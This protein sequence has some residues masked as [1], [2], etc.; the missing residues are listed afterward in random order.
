ML[1]RFRSCMAL[2]HG[3]GRSKSDATSSPAYPQFVRSLSD[4]RR[5][6]ADT[7]LTGRR[8]SLQT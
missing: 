5:S 4:Q 8:P 1:R 2:P 6:T 3:L 7:I